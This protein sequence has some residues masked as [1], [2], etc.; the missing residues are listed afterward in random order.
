MRSKSEILDEI[1]REFKVSHGETAVPVVSEEDPLVQ[2]FG[3]VDLNAKEHGKVYVSEVKSDTQASVSAQGLAKEEAQLVNAPPPKKYAVPN[4]MEG[5]DPKVLTLK[6]T[7]KASSESISSRN[8]TIDPSVYDSSINQRHAKATLAA[9]EP[10][11]AYENIGNK[12]F[13]EVGNTES[14]RLDT[15]LPTQSEHPSDMPYTEPEPPLTEVISPESMEPI[16]SYPQPII[17]EGNPES[18]G[19]TSIGKAQPIDEAI[20]ETDSSNSYQTNP[21][22]GIVSEQVLPP[23]VDSSNTND[24]SHTSQ[25]TSTIS[26]N[27]GSNGSTGPTDSGNTS[28]DYNGLGATD[29]NN[30]ASGNSNTSSEITDGPLGATIG[31]SQSN[32]TDGWIN[33]QGSQGPANWAT[34]QE[35]NVSEIVNSRGQDPSASNS[36]TDSQTL[37]GPLGET[38]GQSQS[39][40]TD[41]WI[42]AQGSQGPANWAT[43]QELN[44][45]DNV[46]TSR[47]SDS[48]G[49]QKAM[50]DHME[51]LLLAESDQTLSST[52]LGDSI[53][54]ESMENSADWLTATEA[55]TSTD[56]LE[57]DLSV[58]DEPFPEIEPQNPEPE[59]LWSHS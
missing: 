10:S 25:T 1:K 46:S 5:Q 50:N 6:S 58:I 40:N 11:Q 14:P 31:Q 24:S 45:S 48:Q 33:A 15:R 18:A 8:A 52:P 44:V 13:S 39:N 38:M 3:N 20:I 32:N 16:D 9:E 49:S 27:S 7:P 2:D 59:E 12:S 19:E 54:S 26:T 36:D 37:D 17:V 34:D 35:L 41:G 42:N 28:S 57:V 4:G 22:S 47:A 30:Q 56:E 29:N 43:D 51:E 55:Q 23:S 21:E 53:A